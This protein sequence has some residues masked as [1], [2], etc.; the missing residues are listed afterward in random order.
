LLSGELIIASIISKP[1]L[2]FSAFSG[3]AGSKLSPIEIISQA[4]ADSLEGKVNDG[5]S[6]YIFVSSKRLTDFGKISA[7]P[8]GYVF[9][10]QNWSNFFDG[11]FWIKTEHPPTY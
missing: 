2:A 4:P 3:S 1:F 7:R 9:K 10:E 11:L 5:N 8:M 6:S